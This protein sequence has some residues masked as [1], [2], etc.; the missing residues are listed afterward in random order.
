VRYFASGKLQQNAFIESFNGR[1]RVRFT[2]QMRRCSHHSHRR[3]VLAAWKNDYNTVRPHSALAN[4][5]PIEYA[6]RCAPN[7]NGAERG[8]TPG[9][10]EGALPRCSTEPIV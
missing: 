5:T 6:D 2:H 7:R 3:A 8:A 4:F 10:P 1:L 9:E